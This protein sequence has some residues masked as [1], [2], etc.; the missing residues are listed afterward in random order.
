M[1]S[2]VHS[3]AW[4]SHKSN[5]RNGFCLFPHTC[6][7][8]KQICINHLSVL[9]LSTSFCAHALLCRQCTCFQTYA[10]I[11]KWTPPTHTVLCHKKPDKC[12][13]IYLFI[14][15]CLCGVVSK[16][17]WWF[18]L[19]HYMDLK[20]EEK[21][22]ANCTTLPWRLLFYLYVRVFLMRARQPK[23]TLGYMQTAIKRKPLN[24]HA[25][26][27]C[28]AEKSKVLQQIVCILRCWWD[29]M[30][31][32][33]I[34]GN[35]AQ[36]TKTQPY[37]PQVPKDL[38]LMF[39][40]QRL[41]EILKCSLSTTANST[42]DEVTRTY[43][44]LISVHGIHSEWLKAIVK[45]AHWV[46]VSSSWSVVSYT[47]PVIGLCLPLPDIERFLSNCEANGNFWNM[48]TKN[49][50]S[51]LTYDDCLWT[52]KPGCL[53]P[54]AGGIVTYATHCCKKPQKWWLVINGSILEGDLLV[55][56]SPGY[57]V[58]II[59]CQKVLKIFFLS[60]QSADCDCSYQNKIAKG[61]PMHHFFYW[62][63][64]VGEVFQFCC[65]CPALKNRNWQ[66]I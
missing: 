19:S 37:I 64:Q 23:Q 11:Q 15:S 42:F 2:F 36:S 14:F 45:T 56:I 46:V 16:V 59:S 6:L 12:R 38:W 20:E 39:Q 31:F 44:W 8:T 30:G 66:K 48:A 43:I 18:W 13:L 47:I 55:L 32:D 34:H 54:S 24:L 21:T 41:Q 1:H 26:T 53:V 61:I 17:I 60:R 9:L 29:L 52:N 58:F 28:R 40:Y 7:L 10:E 63:G 4:M 33:G 62:K 22:G 35:Q 25:V 51:R 5:Q 65:F 27:E 49:I 3:V 57:V 50:C